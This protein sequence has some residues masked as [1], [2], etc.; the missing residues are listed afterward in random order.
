M[1]EQMDLLGLPLAHWNWRNCGPM[2]PMAS[3]MVP[4]NRA[5]SLEHGCSA[6]SLHQSPARRQGAKFHETR[7]RDCSDNPQILGS[8]YV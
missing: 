7:D 6:R 5:K 4:S 3:K 2:A 1:V 8:I